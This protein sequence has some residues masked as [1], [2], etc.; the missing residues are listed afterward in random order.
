VPDQPLGGSRGGQRLP[1]QGAHPADALAD[2]RTVRPADGIASDRASDSIAVVTGS[3]GPFWARTVLTPDRTWVVGRADDADIVV[4]GEQVSRHHLVLERCD[5][6]WLIRDVSSNGSWQDGTRIGTAAVAVPFGTALRLNLGDRAGPQV[7]IEGPPPPV[8]P[9]A[10]APRAAGAEP[11]RR[12][13]RY[14]RIAIALA[15]LVLLLV[16]ADRVAA[17]I[18]STE[19]VSQIVK[20]SQGLTRRPTVSFGGFPFLTQVAFGDYTD[21][22]IGIE[23]ITLPGPV[24]VDSVTGHLQGA[25]IPLS[26]AIGGKVSTIP[27]DHVAATVALRYA[28]LNSFLA[29]QPGQLRLA[30]RHGGVQVTGRAVVAGQ[31]IKVSG[32]AR[33]RAENG[34]LVIAPT[35][36][37]VAGGGT[38][39][40]LLGDA[41]VG[42]GGALSAFPAVSVPLPDLPFHL[43]LTSLHAD[44]GGIVASAAADHIVLNAG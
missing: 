26:T 33:F 13:R 8:V 35:A 17:R 32:S 10:P 11:A 2:Q 15:V 44:A 21:I 39:G 38:L 43:R 3:D 18:A 9:G 22:R 16:V 42:L 34:G 24:R 28:D 6:Q 14:R 5:Q 7:L 37:H 36:L 27:V 41:G 25:H 31:A 29:H 19:A 4:P 1:R 23:G 12:S 20:H 30:G 40:G